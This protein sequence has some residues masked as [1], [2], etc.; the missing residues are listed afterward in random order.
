MD[1]KELLA[2]QEI[3]RIVKGIQL[4]DVPPLGHISVRD[5]QLLYTGAMLSHV[6]KARLD[7]LLAGGET[8]MMNMLREGMDA[9]RKQRDEAMKKYD[10]KPL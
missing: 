10:D 8:H 7:W 6:S 5:A 4:T 2:I 9:L 1:D 3:N